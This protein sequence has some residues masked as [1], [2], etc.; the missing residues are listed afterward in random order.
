MFWEKGN[1]IIKMQGLGTEFTW[2][3]QGEENEQVSLFS[4]FGYPHVLGGFGCC[5]LNQGFFNSV[6]FCTVFFC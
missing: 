2:F 3:L 4:Q 1:P 5:F 6:N